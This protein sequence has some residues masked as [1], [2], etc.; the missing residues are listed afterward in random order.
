MTKDF[1]VF[2]QLGPE[3]DISFFCHLEF[4]RVSILLT[5]PVYTP[6]QVKFVVTYMYCLTKYRKVKQYTQYTYI[7]ISYTRIATLYIDNS[8]V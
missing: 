3:F 5:N 4:N 8:I 7:A 2:L 1:T 6:I